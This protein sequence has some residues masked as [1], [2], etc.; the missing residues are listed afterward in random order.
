MVWDG[1]LS[2]ES[3]L[4]EERFDAVESNKKSLRDM[5]YRGI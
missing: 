3:N 4:I 5:K 1:S 2:K